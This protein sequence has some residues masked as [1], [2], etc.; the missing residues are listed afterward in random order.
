MFPN[1]FIDF[2]PSKQLHDN[3]IDEIERDVDRT[4]PNH[5]LFYH[6]DGLGELMDMHI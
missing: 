5:E 2:D 4:F 3:T 1:P 6:P